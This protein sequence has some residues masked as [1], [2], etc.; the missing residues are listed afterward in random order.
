[1]PTH[2]NATHRYSAEINKDLSQFDSLREF[3][4]EFKTKNFKDLFD[5]KTKGWIKLNNKKNIDAHIFPEDKDLKKRL[6]RALREV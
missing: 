3:A 2:K 4:R 5:H 6:N 1:M